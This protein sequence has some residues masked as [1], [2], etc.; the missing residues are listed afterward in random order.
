LA[1]AYMMNKMQGSLTGDT[2]G[3]DIALQ[4]ALAAVS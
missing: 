2:R 3:T 4:A 1:V